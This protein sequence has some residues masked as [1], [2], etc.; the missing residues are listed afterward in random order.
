MSLVNWSIGTDAIIGF[1]IAILFFAFLIANAV[2]WYNI[3]Y[4]FNTK[5]LVESALTV[6]KSTAQA[7]MILSIIGVVIMFLY[8]GYNFLRYFYNRNIVI[9]EKTV[10]DQVMDA[11]KKAEA[12]AA[13]AAEAEKLKKSAVE[14]V[15]KAEGP[16]LFERTKKGFTGNFPPAKEDVKVPEPKPAPGVRNSMLPDFGKKNPI[17]QKTCEDVVV[18]ADIENAKLICAKPNKSDKPQTSYVTQGDNENGQPVYNIIGTIPTNEGN[19]ANYTFKSN[20]K[21]GVTIGLRPT[22]QQPVPFTAGLSYSMPE[23]AST[24]PSKPFVDSSLSKL[25]AFPSGLGQSQNITNVVSPAG[26]Q[27]STPAAS[28]TVTPAAT[29]PVTPTASPKKPSQRSNIAMSSAPSTSTSTST[30]TTLS[31][32]LSRR[33]QNIPATTTTATSSTTNNSIAYNLGPA[34][35]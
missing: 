29:P 35:N 11:N 24:E 25:A 15:K 34:P 31:T 19:T 22:E 28:A 33:L 3:V 9:A 6:S 30:S 1:I 18:K 4:E 17:V 2:Y 5:S 27:T 23:R 26:S 20:V 13:I 10:V 21:P 8:G 12:K 32:N 7:F 16:S 14:A